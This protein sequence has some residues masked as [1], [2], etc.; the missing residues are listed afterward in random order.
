MAEIYPFQQQILNGIKAGEFAI[1]SAGRNT[2]K[3]AL[4]N[5]WNAMRNSYTPTIK[6]QRLPGLKLQAYTDD[7]APR[8]FERGLNETDMDPVQAWTEECN[9]GTRMSFNVWK[10]KN[11]KQIT[12]FLIRWAS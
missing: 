6:W 5:Y 11:E 1:I 12:M 7:V 8:G 4:I 10:F 9:C 3:S 2:G